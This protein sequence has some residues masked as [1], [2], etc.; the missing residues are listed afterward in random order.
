[1]KQVLLVCVSLVAVAQAASR[2]QIYSALIENRV[3]NPD[4]ELVHFSYACALHVDKAEYP[5]VDLQEL[6]KS[7]RSPRGIN[8]IVVLN[9]QLKPVQKIEYTS[10]RPLFCVENRLYVFGDLEIS[11]T[12]PEGNVL[13][14]SEHGRVIKLDHIEA[15]EYPIPITR[16]RKSPPQ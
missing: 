11:N 7:S 5:V 3:L 6:V 14:F 4:R 10:Q 2:T 13:T 15:S 8:W 9:P 1:M 16:D 12:L